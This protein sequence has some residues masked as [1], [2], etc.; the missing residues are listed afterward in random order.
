[1]IWELGQDYFTGGGYGAPSLLPAI[2]STIGAAWETWTG[3]A[4]SDWTNPSN[5]NFGQA[6]ASAT[7]VVINK[8]TPTANSPFSVNSLS[9][10]GGALTLNATLATYSTSALSVSGGTLNIGSNIVN[11]NYGPAADPIAAIAAD[12]RSGYNAGSWTGKGITSSAAAA[13]ATSYGI[14][15]ADAADANNPAS[16]AT[17]QLEFRYTLLGDAN[18]DGKVNGADFAILA[19]AFNQAVSGWD[20]GD[21]NYDGA[22]NG[23]DFAFLAGNF[24]Q[25][26]AAPA[27]VAPAAAVPAV[28]NT[29]GSTSD[30]STATLIAVPKHRR[31]QAVGSHVPK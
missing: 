20:Q 2:K 6:P 13:N 9:I 26:V 18:L 14:G 10:N 16:L 28:A 1:M 17:G 8:G 31:N 29:T 15:Y 3:A 27:I 22:A 21:F 25:G 19:A 30:S 7:N 4:S 23:A 24:N 5:W 12:I 11:V